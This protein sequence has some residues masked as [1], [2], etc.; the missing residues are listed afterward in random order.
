M[1]GKSEEDR[2]DGGGLPPPNKR[3]KLLESGVEQFH[4]KQFLVAR[5]ICHQCVSEHIAEF[6]EGLCSL[7]SFADK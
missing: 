2:V 5:D 4:K 7:Y 1:S 6:G 3:D